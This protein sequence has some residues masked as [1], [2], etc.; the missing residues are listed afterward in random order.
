MGWQRSSLH[1]SGALSKLLCKMVL[2]GIDRRCQ[3]W[4]NHDLCPAQKAKRMN[5]HASFARTAIPCLA[6]LQQEEPRA[7]H[8]LVPAEIWR[9]ISMVADGCSSQR[10]ILSY[11]WETELLPLL[12][13]VSEC[14][15][16][17]IQWSFGRSHPI[18]V[19]RPQRHAFSALI[20]T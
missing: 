14:F 3:S 17:S 19:P 20:I 4:D 1:C 6:L 2:S 11:R 10:D 16:C 13:Q 8:S 5:E 18:H 7:Y 9:S 12:P 15:M